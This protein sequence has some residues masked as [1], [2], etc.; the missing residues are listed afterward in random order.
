MPRFISLLTILIGFSN[1]SLSL[2]QDVGLGHLDLVT[3][4]AEDGSPIVTR[5]QVR[6]EQGAIAALMTDEMAALL[7]LNDQQRDAIKALQ[8]DSMSH[9]LGEIEQIGEEFPDWD[10]EQVALIA[11]LETD[12]E[13]EGRVEGILSQE[14]F[15]KLEQRMDLAL[16]KSAGAFGTLFLPRASQR[17]N[18]SD[19]ELAKLRREV[20]ELD[21]QLS[22]EF[23]ERRR[24]E[25]ARLIESAP[26]SV[27]ARLR[28]AAEASFDNGPINPG[29]VS[30]AIRKRRDP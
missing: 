16:A 6:P 29:I 15:E 22:R 10:R 13:F 27:R 26:A 5:I 4:V 9:M 21:R 28:E 25:T 19:Q 2:C 23:E 18:L 30:D 8:S 3:A 24:A 20:L 7:E 14:Q 1:A 12:S 11:G 17:L